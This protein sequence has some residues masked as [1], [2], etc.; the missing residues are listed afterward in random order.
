MAP[1]FDPSLLPPSPDF[2]FE[3]PLWEHGCQYVA[4]FDEAGRGALAGPVV[5]AVVIFPPGTA[6]RMLEG[7]RDSK[8]M[9]PST[10]DQWAARL[11]ELALTWGVGFTSPQEIDSMGIISATRAA[12]QHVITSLQ[13]VP[14]HILLDYLL[15]PD[16]PVP[17]TSLIKGDARS[18]SIAAASVMAKTARDAR[19]KDLDA[20]YPGYGFAQHKGYGTA[21]HLAVLSSR[22][23]SPIHR[24]SYKPLVDRSAHSVVDS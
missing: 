2:S 23:P 8:E 9:T 13:V 3:L 14:Q 7:V 4:G 10:R 20:Q 12:A 11:R 21:A 24:L 6:L 19:L 15:L 22:G 16:S 17:Q 5:A 18:M 1:R